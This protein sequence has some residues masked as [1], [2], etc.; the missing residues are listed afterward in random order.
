MKKTTKLV[1]LQNP[2]NKDIWFCQDYNDEKLIDG[3]KYISVFKENNPDKKA[4]IRKEAL[5]KLRK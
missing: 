5:K 3:V 4:L 1:K 2:V